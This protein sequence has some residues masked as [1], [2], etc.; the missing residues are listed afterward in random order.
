MAFTDPQKVKIGTE[1]TLPRISTGDMTSKYSNEDGTVVLTIATARTNSNRLRH[2]FR[3][4]KSKVT[5][6]P[7]DTTQNIDVSC[8]AYLVV[9]RPVAGFTAAEV[10]EVVKGLSEALSA[11]TYAAVKKVLAKE[12]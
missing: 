2:T 4:D 11:S 6:D 1:I 9:D 10:E 3:I 5:T 7:Y 12:S 8:S